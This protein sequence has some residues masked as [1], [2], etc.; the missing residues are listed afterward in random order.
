MSAGSSG[1]EAVPLH[2]A[3]PEQLEKEFF[4]PRPDPELAPEQFKLWQDILRRN[5]KR[6]RPE[7]R[8]ELGKGLPETKNW[9]GAILSARDQNT[10][11]LMN[12]YTKPSPFNLIRGSL[13]IPNPQPLIK[14]SIGDRSYVDG[15]Y[16]LY[17]Y[18]G[19]D[20]WQNEVSLKVGVESGIDVLDGNIKEK[21]HHAA[22][23]FRGPKEQPMSYYWFNKN[24]VEPGDLITAYVWTTPDG[25]V[26]KATL[27]NEA[28]NIYDGGELKP[29]E[30]G[31]V[32]KGQSGEWV[33]SGK[34]PDAP[35]NYRMPHYGATAFFN[36][37]VTR[38]DKREQS[39][40][41]AML[42]DSEEVNSSARRRDEVLMYSGCRHPNK[43][44]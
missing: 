13:V 7:H 3:T 33:I 19:L 18:I 16:R 25:K 4:P 10:Q 41:E 8:P 38:K 1:V 39:M 14:D 5:P 26:G 15:K 29:P 36:G 32:V 31:V 17:S 12:A 28:K 42:A 43:Q 37:F 35:P 27:I 23:L 9:S 24:F 44:Y 20:G 40:S 22:I 34:N 11:S 30:P 21:Y 6:L 2:K